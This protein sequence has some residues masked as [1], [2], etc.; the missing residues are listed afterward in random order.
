[1]VIIILYVIFKNAKPIDKKVIVDVEDDWNPEVISKTELELRLEAAMSRED[2]R[3][4]SDIFHVYPKR[5][6]PKVMD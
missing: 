6:D 1:M 3:M 4:C 2:Y 5:I